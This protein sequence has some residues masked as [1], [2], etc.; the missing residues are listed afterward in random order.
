[1]I[2]SGL[3]LSHK[4]CII[5]HS[6]DFHSHFDILIATISLF[7]IF[8]INFQGMKTSFLSEGLKGFTNQ[9]SHFLLALNSHIIS[10]SDLL[11]IF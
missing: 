10:L 11:M 8:S 5:F 6:G 2:L 3:F 9:K 1:M 4:T 7:S